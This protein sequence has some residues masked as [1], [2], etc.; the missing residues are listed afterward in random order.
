[1]P[2]TLTLSLNDCLLGDFRVSM[3]CDHCNFGRHAHLDQLVRVAGKAA[4][5]PII[6]LF[7]GGKLVCSRCT[8]PWAGLTVERSGSRPLADT[9]IARFWRPG[10]RC[11]P[12]VDGYWRGVREAKQAG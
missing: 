5:T 9:V 12:A 4:N 10:S 2:V 7:D 6:Q 11:D 3:Y 8:K 1:M